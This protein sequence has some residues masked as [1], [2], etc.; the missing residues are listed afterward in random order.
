MGGS[1]THTLSELETKSGFDKRTIAY[2]V[3]EGLLPK[4]G[5]RGRRTRYSEDFLDRLMFIRRVR[6]LQDAGKL[7]AV[8]LSEIRDVLDR[9]SAE[10]IRAGSRR[11]VSAETLRSLFAEP[12]LDTSGMAVASEEIAALS[13]R[14]ALDLDSADTRSA[15]FMRRP[16]A[17]SARRDAAVMKM[18]VGSRIDPREE[19]ATPSE[20]EDGSD[21]AL[22]T[23]LQEVEGLARRGSKQSHGQARERLTRVPVTEDITLSVRNIDDEDAHLVEK[24][25]KLLRRLGRLG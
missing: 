22:T 12:D 1:D 14:D 8:T 11:G 2:Y 7:R 10:E 25:A 15:R 19:E 21:A 5:R 3:Q 16:G 18:R 13:S 23:L 20:S 24:L 9:Q 17:A 6:D 4:V